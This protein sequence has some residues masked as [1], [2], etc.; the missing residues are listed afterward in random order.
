[1]LACAGAATGQT[2]WSNSVGGNWNLATNWS[3]ADVPNSIAE[4]ASLPNLGTPYTVSLD[5]SVNILGCGLHSS[6]ALNVLEGRSLTIDTG[7]ILNNGVIVV[8]SGGS[9]SNAAIRPSAAFSILGSGSIELNATTADLGDA[10]IDGAD[11]F[12]ITIGANQLVHGSGSIDG[13]IILNGTVEADR[14]GRELSLTGTHDLTGGGV[15]RGINNGKILVMGQVSGGTLDGGVEASGAAAGVAGSISNGA[16]GVRSGSTLHLSGAGM[17]NTGTWVVNTA[18]TFSDA[19][20]LADESC[21][22]AGA[23][24]IELNSTTTDRGDARLEGQAGA[25]LTIGG[26]QSVNGSGHVAG[27]ITLNGTI[28]ADRADRDILVVGNIDASGGGTLMGTG[29]GHVALQAAVTGGTLAGGVEAESAAPSVSATS[30]TGNNGVRPSANLSILSGGLTND[31]TLT[32][33][34]SGVFS[35]AVLR[36]AESATLDGSGNIDLNSTTTDLND[37]RLESHAG[38]LTVGAAQSITGSGAVNGDFVFNG[39]VNADRD[40]RDLAAQGSFDMTGGGTMMGTN[41]GKV[42][43]QA[44]TTGGSFAGGVEAAG[45]SASVDGVTMSG[46][47]GVRPGGTLSVFSGG[48]TNDGTLTVNTVDTFT[49]AVL[50]FAESCV[51]DGVGAVDLNATTTD[52]FDAHISM[53]ASVVVSVGP[54]HSFTGSGVI[55]GTMAL[56][57]SIVADRDLRDLRVEADVDMTGGGSISGINGGKAAA[58]G[59]VT[60]GSWLGG[61]E[62][63]TA[64]P[65][66]DGVTMSGSNGIRPGGTLS[67]LGSGFT[68]NGTLVVNTTG[69]FTNA[70]LMTE[71]VCSIDGAGSIHLN[72]QT[73]DHYDAQLGTAGAGDLSVGADQSII[74]QGAVNGLVHIAGTLA[75]G[76]ADDQT[77]SIQ[78]DGTPDLGSGSTT[79]IGIADN[80]VGEFD[81]ITGNGALALDGTLELSLLDGFTPAFEDRFTIIDVGSLTGQFHTVVSPAVGLGIFRIVQTADKVEAV[82]TCQ[83]DLNGDG[84]LD[85]FDVQFFLN[86]FADQA[87]YGD[88]NEDGVND[89]FDVQAFL[90]DF[91]TGCL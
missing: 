84:I 8:N 23:G 39:T 60:S 77:D 3:P 76:D 73:T 71:S 51:V 4:S 12:S 43:M 1:M 62:A 78:M 26:S 89:F 48:M 80:P 85:F 88:Y 44:A 82:W 90:N 19:K 30:A 34:T 91:S 5:T 24:N 64:T 35:D 45:A 17:L 63:E 79:A 16:N 86:A 40:L 47:N 28:D 59:A 31:G 37:A 70:T 22:I 18:G 57:G 21:T 11:P 69:A 67:I 41:G 20:I 74:G 66:I 7:G 38:V 36:A 46:D 13:P 29:G 81:Q 10:M 75:P 52:L 15:V 65:T 2:L 6:A 83:A 50:H 25:T 9:F 56:E 58:R 87:L 49:N 14:D 27:P 54:D 32:V 72:G 61:V 33:N 55:Q 53:A 42:S 68:N